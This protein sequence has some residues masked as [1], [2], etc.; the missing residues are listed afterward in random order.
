ML[1]IKCCLLVLCLLSGYSNSSRIGLEPRHKTEIEV[2]WLL[3][4]LV[5]ILSK[6]ASDIETAPTLL[7]SRVFRSVIIRVLVRIT[8]VIETAENM[9]NISTRMIA[10]VTRLDAIRVKLSN[11][12]SNYI[13]STD[14]P[15]TTTVKTS[16]TTDISQ[17]ETSDGPDRVYNLDEVM[18][19]LSNVQTKLQ[20]MNDN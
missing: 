2:E 11:F 1:A 6:F 5:T 12:V 19:I 13:T 8:E 14:A 4:Q 3:D 18:D 10:S 16:D 17:S 7:Q 20:Q 15:K 9:P